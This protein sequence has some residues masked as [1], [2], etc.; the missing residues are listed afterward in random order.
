MTRS[1]ESRRY[2][3]NLNVQFSFRRG[4]LEKT[5]KKNVAV[6]MGASALTSMGSAIACQ[7]CNSFFFVSDFFTKCHLRLDWNVLRVPL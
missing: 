2:V 6:K 3:L 5:V 4:R 7:V 1:I